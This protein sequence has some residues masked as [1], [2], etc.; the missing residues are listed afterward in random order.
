MLNVII[1]HTEK[2]FLKRGVMLSP[3]TLCVRLCG[4]S[5]CRPVC[6]FSDFRGRYETLMIIVVRPVSP[7]EGNLRQLRKPQ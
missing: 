5:K 2:C 3:H 1:A 4:R 6:V 7:T